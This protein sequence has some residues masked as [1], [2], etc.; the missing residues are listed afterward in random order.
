LFEIRRQS[1]PTHD[2]LR[3]A[4]SSASKRPGKFSKI[5]PW[6][7]HQNVGF[8]DQIFPLSRIS[9]YAESE[10]LVFG[11]GIARPAGLRR[12]SQVHRGCQKASWL[13]TDNNATEA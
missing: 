9:S 3:K 1:N 4:Y 6:K 13:H 10:V 8:Y 5:E 2:N 7:I 12:R 11:D